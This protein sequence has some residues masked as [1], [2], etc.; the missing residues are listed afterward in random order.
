[1]NIKIS[2]YVYGIL[3]VI[4]IGKIERISGG[5]FIGFHSDYDMKSVEEYKEKRFLELDPSKEKVVEALRKESDIVF[6]KK[7]VNPYRREN[8]GDNFIALADARDINFDGYTTFKYTNKASS[9][10]SPMDNMLHER[11]LLFNLKSIRDSYLDGEIF[12]ERRSKE[13][14]EELSGPTIRYMRSLL[15]ITLCHYILERMELLEDIKRVSVITINALKGR[16]IQNLEVLSAIGVREEVIKMIKGVFPR[17]INRIILEEKMKIQEI[18]FTEQ[19]KWMEDLEYM[20]G[21]MYWNSKVSTWIK[22]IEGNLLREKKGYKQRDEIHFRVI[23]S[24]Y[25][26][27]KLLMKKNG[28]ISKAEVYE[29]IWE[30]PLVA[31]YLETTPT[32]PA[33]ICITYKKRNGTIEKERVK[34]SIPNIEFIMKIKNEKDI[35]ELRKQR[36]HI[37]KGNTIQNMEQ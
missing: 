8:V 23:S 34:P 22:D 33:H 17:N 36:I 6:I 4:T 21:N 19:V 24:L 31:M 27:I 16:N 26:L 15:N 29:R 10:L 9:A 14:I 18:R 5:S 25:N 7:M 32:I 11:N 12:L 1:M 3:L 2:K 37:K 13:T 30:Y 35:D 20:F 28:I